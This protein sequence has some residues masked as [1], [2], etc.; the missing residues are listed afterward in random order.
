MGHSFDPQHPCHKVMMGSLS[1]SQCHHRNSLI[2]ST[3]LT[4]S[5]SGSLCSLYPGLSRAPSLKIGPVSRWGMRSLSVSRELHSCHL[6]YLATCRQLSR[7]AVSGPGAPLLPSAHL[8]P[9]LVTIIITSA[10]HML[11]PGPKHPHNEMLRVDKQGNKSPCHL[12]LMS[13]VILVLWN[14]YSHSYH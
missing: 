8:S 14:C 11:T 13:Y 12:K 7:P 3:H 6:H 2:I 10:P 4:Q 1:L 5:I 9:S